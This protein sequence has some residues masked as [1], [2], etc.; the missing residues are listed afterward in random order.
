MPNTPITMNKLRTIIRLYEDHTGLKSISSMARTSR[1]TIK[2][3]INKW[4]SLNMSYEE[5]QS[6]TVNDGDNAVMEKLS[7]VFG[8]DLSESVKKMCSG[9]TLDVPHLFTTTETARRLRVTKRTLARYRQRGDL[10]FTRVGNRA[11]Y[12]EED[13][14]AFLDKNAVH[15]NK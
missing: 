9:K 5:F 2:K 11:Y 12:S 7:A 4:N 13:I 10:P 14:R 3:Y 15:F 1:N 8:N 6:I